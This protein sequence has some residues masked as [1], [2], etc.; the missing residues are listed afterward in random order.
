[1]RRLLFVL[2]LLCHGLFLVPEAEAAERVALVFGNS[3][4]RNAP[5]L[6]NPTNDATDV[7]AAFERLGF[8]VHRITNGSFD[9]M[10]R[11][12]LDFAQQTSGADIAVIYFA[13]H[14][15]EIRDENWLIPIDA[16]LRLDAS[17]SQEAISLGNVMPII[18]RARKLGLVI[19]DA[20]RD[21]PFGRQMLLSQPGRAVAPR[22]LVPVEPPNSVLVAF[23][24]KHGTT[25]D[26]GSG[27]NSPF[28]TALLHNLETPGLEIN[29]LF[30][31]VHDEVYSATQHQQEPY[32]YGTLS[33]EPIYLKPETGLQLAATTSVGP[34][35]TDD[36]AERAWANIKDT[37]D[38][39]VLETF[40]K[41]FGGSFYGDLASKKL[42]QLKGSEA[43]LSPGAGNSE[44]NGKTT[45]PAPAPARPS[46]QVG[47]TGSW[48]W[49]ADCGILGSPHGR[50]EIVQSADS[51]LVGRSFDD[52][53]TTVWPLID[54]RAD[55]KSMSF[56]KKT[57]FA[58]IQTW[59]GTIDHQKN[60][61]T[62][63]RGTF[64]DSKVPF[65][66]CPWNAA[67]N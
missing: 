26:D 44:G 25:A 54:G 45:T 7:A 53:T 37:Q 46:D 14:G 41:H 29:Y 40:I 67:Q 3:D 2:I 62:I 24:A 10:R 42:N 19:L 13:G 48:S 21:N 27:R 61:R 17:A 22:G 1:M 66:S 59:N 38:P 39:G 52:S 23:A 63:I 34:I 16:E 64:T 35:S 60:G 55:G 57:M 32:I 30:R 5:R 36:Q 56:R 15:M 43:S 49:H 4:Y 31:N 51:K 9:T 11:A 33:K 12:L 50:L 28:T 8:S 6:P 58:S 47:L 18:S 20:C 65:G